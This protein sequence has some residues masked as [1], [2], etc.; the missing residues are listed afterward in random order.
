MNQ[1]DVDA[2]TFLIAFYAFATSIMA[3][4]RPC[5]ADEPAFVKEQSAIVQQNKGGGIEAIFDF[6]PLPAGKRGVL[7]LTLVN[8]TPV[9]FEFNKIEAGCNCL[10]IDAAGNTIPANGRLTIEA[11]LS[12]PSKVKVT[13]QMIG[14]Y[15]KMKNGN[16]LAVRVGYDVEGALSFPEQM[17]VTTSFLGAKEHIFAIPLIVSAPVS[18]HNLQATGSEDFKDVKTRFIQKDGATFVECT[19]QLGGRTED[20]RSGG[21]TIRD[22]VSGRQDAVRCMVEAASLI[23]V[24]PTVARFRQE[25]GEDK[26][27]EIKGRSQL[28]VRFHIAAL[29]SKDEVPQMHFRFDGG[30][31][32]ATPERIADGIFRVALQLTI[33]KQLE[34]GK[35]KPPRITEKIRWSIT[36][37]KTSR[38]GEIE[39]QM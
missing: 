17:H 39:V 9:E 13:R 22:N 28:L 11:E 15:L 14:L 34:E 19:I 20:G 30:E 23:I 18:I 26:D 4:C 3:L 36:T 24:A 21:L 31:L 33:K 2:R 6:D 10:K 25:L 1:C 37:K 35:L 29:E 27:G 32:L 7:L 16:A 38:E 8:D 5:F 12:T